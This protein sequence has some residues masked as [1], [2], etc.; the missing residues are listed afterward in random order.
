MLGL[1]H[2]LVFTCAVFFLSF[3][4][5]PFGPAQPPIE[6][7]L[8]RLDQTIQG[9]DGPGTA[10]AYN[11][12]FGF[13][14]A[15]CERGTIQLWNKDV[16]LGVRKGDHPTNVLRGH[17]GAVLCLATCQG[18]VLASA[19]IDRTILIWSLLEGKVLHTIPSPSNVRCL[20]LSPDGKLLASG[21]HDGVIHLWDSRTGKPKGI[22]KEGSDWLTNLTFN[23]DGKAIVSGSY[24]G[25]VRVWDVDERKLVMQGPLPAS[26]AK[27]PPAGTI[28]DPR[29]SITALVLAPNHKEMALG[30]GDGVIHIVD[31]AQGRI[32][33]SMSGHG[34]AITAL[35]FHPSA[36]LLVSASKDR[37]LRLW[38]PSNGQNIKALE[39]HT[40][41]VQGVVFIGNGTRLASVAADQTVRLWVLEK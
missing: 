22:L 30:G 2:T 38:N 1:R 21:G 6:P 41:W 27:P 4:L 29:P 19:G 40:G 32:L 16:L 10:L 17:K 23:D 31:R 34:S 20:A 7:S 11:E 13:L 12:A 18:P 28:A 26:S 36:N 14:A 37:T 8:A 39:G 9:L 3:A 15:G 24:D 33:R 5:V 25:R 35:A